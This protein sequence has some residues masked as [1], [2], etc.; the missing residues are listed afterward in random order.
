MVPKHSK[1]NCESIGA[2]IF[3]SLTKVNAYGSF[4]DLVGHVVVFC[5]VMEWELEGC[6]VEVGEVEGSIL[7]SNISKFL[8]RLV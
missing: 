1:P 3:S 4:V 7:R 2:C 8:V 5:E 6:V